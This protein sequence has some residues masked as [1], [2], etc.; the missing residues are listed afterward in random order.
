MTADPYADIA[1]AKKEAAEAED[2]LAALE[3][4]V[5]DGDAKVKPAQLAEQREL[6]RFAALRVEAAHRNLQRAAQQEVDAAREQYATDVRTLAAGDALD[7]A[8]VAAAYTALSEAATAFVATCNTYNAAWLAVRDR[9]HDAHLHGFT[10]PDGGALGV[11][12]RASVN[13]HPQIKTADRSLYRI[14]TGDHLA[15]A[16]YQAARTEQRGNAIDV[17]RPLAGPAKNATAYQPDLSG[18][19]Q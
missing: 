17:V 19:A 10:G 4:R 8:Q 15:R 9:L 11:S 1:A 2:L 7:P 3:E 14:R 12:I 5:R 6:A 16:V 13:G 18:G